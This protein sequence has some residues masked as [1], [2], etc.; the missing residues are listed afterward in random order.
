MPPFLYFA[1]SKENATTIAKSGLPAQS[2]MTGVEGY[3]TTLRAQASDII[4]R[5]ASAKLNA[6]NWKESGAGRKEWRGDSIP[7]AS[8]E[9]RRNLGTPAQRTWRGAIFYPQGMQA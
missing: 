5:V 3:A 2:S 1:T 8:L 7:A 4:F 9:Y 6:G